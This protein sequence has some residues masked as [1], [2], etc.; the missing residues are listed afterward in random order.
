MAL[1]V[2]DRPF[3]YSEYARPVCL[4]SGLLDIHPGTTCEITQWR[5]DT[6]LMSH[7]SVKIRSCRRKNRNVICSDGIGVLVN[8]VG[9]PLVC[10]VD[11]GTMIS[12][13]VIGVAVTSNNN[14]RRYTNVSHFTQWIRQH[15]GNQHY[16]V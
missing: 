11:D 16:L 3:D 10:K 12:Y 7:S 1:I 13:I 2:L 8:N 14:Q 15:L 6:E 4:P 5:S 9:S